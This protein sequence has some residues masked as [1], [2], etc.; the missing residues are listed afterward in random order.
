[1]KFIKNTIF[2]I[3]VFPGADISLGIHLCWHGLIDLHLLNFMVSVGRIPIYKDKNG[4]CFAV[5]N[6]FHLTRGKTPLRAGTP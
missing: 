5:A 1:M 4:R 3:T 2:W 6:S